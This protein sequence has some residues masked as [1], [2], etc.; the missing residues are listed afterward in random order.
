M[1]DNNHFKINFFNNDN[2]ID[3]TKECFNIIIQGLI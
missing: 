1:V 3:N 2:Y